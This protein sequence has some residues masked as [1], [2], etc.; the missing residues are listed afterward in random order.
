[1]KIGI[2]A[3]STADLTKEII[4]KYNIE[5]IHFNVER[6]GITYPDDTF[7]TSE[8]FEFT[9]KTKKMCHTSAPNVGEYEKYFDKLLNKYDEIIHFTMSSKLSS[10]YDNAVSAT[11]DNPRIKIIDTKGTSGATALLIIYAL[12]LRDTGYNSDEIYTR[13]LQRVPFLSTSFVIKD[14]DY[15]YKGGRCTGLKY[16]A[17]KLLRLR[18]VIETNKDGAFVI[19]KIYRGE[20]QK[21]IKKYIEDRLN[22]F[23]DIDFDGAYINISTCD[24]ET[25]EM[26]KNL[27]KEKGFKNIYFTEASPTNSYHAGPSVL[28]VQFL[29]DG[30]QIIKPKNN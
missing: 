29:F 6:D 21:C 20:S 8:L 11:H 7:K 3:T 22:M 13:C 1:M 19:G 9:N 12:K 24:D 30:E 14:L 17:S 10:C 26:A 15:L 25:I 27:L 16:Y 18:P 28:G 2:T 4:D 23:S 5:I